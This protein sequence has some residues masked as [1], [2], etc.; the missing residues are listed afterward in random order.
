MAEPPVRVVEPG[1]GVGKRTAL[2]DELA[3]VDQLRDMPVTPELRK[4][5]EG[6]G[7]FIILCGGAGP[8]GGHQNRGE[9]V[10]GDGGVQAFSFLRALLATFRRHDHVHAP[11]AGP[12]YLL[13]G[14]WGQGGK[15][16]AG[17]RHRQLVGW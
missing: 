5:H 12:R 11:N 4:L 7:Q 3:K 6:F 17:A 10:D 15:E 2:D 14:L 8:E 9:G 13:R 16:G 1:W